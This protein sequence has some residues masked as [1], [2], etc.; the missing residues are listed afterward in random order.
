[1]VMWPLGILKPADLNADLILP[2]DSLIDESQRPMTEKVGMPGDM[3][4]SIRDKVE[5]EP[6][7]KHE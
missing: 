7:V 4:T 2:S 1:M 3:D 5:S 6:V